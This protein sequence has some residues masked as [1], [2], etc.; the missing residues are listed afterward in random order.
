M[1]K[2]IF[3]KEELVY[4]TGRGL[5]WENWNI[6]TDK[7]EKIYVDE[8]TDQGR[9]STHHRLVFQCGD[10]VYETSYSTGSTE[11][12]EEGPWEYENDVVCYE[13]EEIE[14]IRKEWARVKNEESN[15][16]PIIQTPS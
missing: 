2:R 5:P 9:W 15:D 3:K 1:T 4:D 14:V 8:I 13:V 12:Q 10:K 16:L 6:E 7:Q 11:S